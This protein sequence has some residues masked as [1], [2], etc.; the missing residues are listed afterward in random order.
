MKAGRRE[1]GI[2][3]LRILLMIQIVFLHISLYGGYY[4]MAME[5]G[6]GDSENL[7]GVVDIVP[8]SSSLDVY[9]DWL[10]YGE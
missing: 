7:G 1:S 6:G 4:D 8:V 10:F 5:L 3:L 9:I 2:E